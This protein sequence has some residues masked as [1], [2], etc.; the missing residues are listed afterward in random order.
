MASCK[1]LNS[2]KLQFLD[3]KNRNDYMK[4]SMW[5]LLVHCLTQDKS[6]IITGCVLICFS[7]VQVCD[8]VD[9]SLPGSSVHGI[10]QARTLE[11]VAMPSSR[12]SSQPRGWT[13]G[14]LH[15]LHWRAGSLPLVPPGKLQPSLAMVIII[16]TSLAS[17]RQEIAQAAQPS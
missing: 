10:L 3:L 4:E 17:T 16:P 7:R 2:F 8:P 14:F 6:S 12:G 15:L 9:Y 5:K 13:C 1:I 11:W